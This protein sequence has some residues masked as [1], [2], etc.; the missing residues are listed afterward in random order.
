ALYR[1]HEPGWELMHCHD[2][3]PVLPIDLVAAHHYT[4]TYPLVSFRQ[5]LMLARHS[6][7]RH[8]TIT[9]STVTIRRPG[10]PTEHRRISVFEAIDLLRE[11]A[12][13]LTEPELLRLTD[14]LL[15]LRGP[16]AEPSR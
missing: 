6:P 3:L 11:L 12:V 7:D 4:S 8:T 10:Q 5:G 14:T 2:E 9:D 15:A 16:A 1:R 13:P